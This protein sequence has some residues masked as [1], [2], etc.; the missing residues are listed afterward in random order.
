MILNEK[1][2]LENL[3]KEKN[4]KEIYKYISLMV[5]EKYENGNSKE[6]A[7]KDVSFELKN[8]LGNN[9]DELKYHD[10]ITKSISIMYKYKIGLKTV[11]Y[12]SISNNEMEVI[13]SRKDPRDGRMLFSMLVYTKIE[14]AKGNSGWIKKLDEMFKSVKLT[15]RT[16]EEKIKFIK[17]SYDE[18]LVKFYFDFR[19]ASVNSSVKMVG[20]TM[21]HDKYVLEEDLLFEIHDLN[22]FWLYYDYYVLGDKKLKRCEECGVIIK[23][24]KTKPP[25]YCKLCKV[26]MQKKWD[27][28]SKLRRKL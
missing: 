10:V 22:N 15:S 6:E 26:K 12:I 2:V 3:R 8:K 25:K 18:K 28:D 24:G 16:Q 11:D 13:K 5:K 23:I 19:K 7:I 9:Y 27:L 14:L 17:P 4:I 20:K 1:V 21:F